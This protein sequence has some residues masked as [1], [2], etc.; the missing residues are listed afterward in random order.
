MRRSETAPSDMRRNIGKSAF[1]DRVVT[2]QILHAGDSD[3]L[4]LIVPH[5]KTPSLREGV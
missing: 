3:I 1:L 4:N 2:G 5:K